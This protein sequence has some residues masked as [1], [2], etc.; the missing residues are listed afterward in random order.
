VEVRL[1][2]HGNVDKV[3]VHDPAILSVVLFRSGILA[4]L[5]KHDPTGKAI[6]KRSRPG[7]SFC[8]YNPKRLHVRVRSQIKVG[9]RSYM[10]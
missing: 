2:M 6:Q 7:I 10:C 5:G 3:G 4:K 1:S 8:L 9:L